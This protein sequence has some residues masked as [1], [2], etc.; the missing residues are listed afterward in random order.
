MAALQLPPTRVA[1]AAP[2]TEE[3]EELR[4]AGVILA[5]TAMALLRACVGFFTFHVAFWLR[6]SG[7]PTWWFGII[8]AASAGGSL[9]GSA[10]APSVRR[11]VREER[12]LVAVL[13][14]TALAG[15][16]AAI[17]GGRGAAMLL[18]V[19]LA[20]SAAAGKLAFD[21]IVQ[22][23]APDANQG[24]AFARFETRF[25]MA[26]VLAGFLPVV[27]RMPGWAGFLL[28]GMTAA[29]AAVTYLLS[30]RR[31]V[32]TGQVP[33]PIGQRVREEMRRRARERAERPPSNLPPPPPGPPPGGTAPPVAYSG[34]DGP[35]S[36]ARSPFRRRPRA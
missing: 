19:V 11:V 34:G 18:A 31:V 10:V 6:G 8:I 36:V 1:V 22:R 4:S 3:T 30:T 9:L 27:V 16:L 28:I 7:A 32:R 17:M 20:A 12:I 33:T 24:R 15:V 29:A 21:S 35:V 25:Q 23:D 13:A 26:W 5:A 2:T 14:L